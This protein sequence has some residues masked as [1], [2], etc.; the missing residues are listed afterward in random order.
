MGQPC[1]TDCCLEAVHDLV[2]N[3]SGMDGTADDALRFPLPA[4]F[5]F[6]GAVA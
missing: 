6:C 3:Q 1:R 2:S 5:V 4:S